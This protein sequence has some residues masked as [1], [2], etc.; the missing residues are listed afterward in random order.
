MWQHGIKQV[1]MPLL[2]SVNSEIKKLAKKFKNSPMLA[3][4]HGQP[5]TPTTF[6]KELAVFYARTN[7]QILTLKNHK[8]SG[9]KII[10]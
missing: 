6:G 1:Y 2:K 7:R 5:A 10:Y 3:L 9:P 8:I 4:T